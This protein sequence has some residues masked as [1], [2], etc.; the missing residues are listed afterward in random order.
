MTKD[1]KN[2]SNEVVS[3]HVRIESMGLKKKALKK[4]GQ[5]GLGL[6]QAALIIG[7][8]GATAEAVDAAE[9]AKY[10]EGSEGAKEA[11]NQALKVARSKPA[12][13]IAAGITCL[14]Y[15][16]AAGV[17]SSPS[18]CVTCGILLA[19]TLGQQCILFD[20]S[21]SNRC[22]CL[23]LS[24]IQTEIGTE[25]FYVLRDDMRNCSMAI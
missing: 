6:L 23:N 3:T 14:A 4:L 9:A 19:K 24:S 21:D 7:S 22:Y 18:I 20:Q 2:S 25:P 16:P 12:L 11:V 15:I 5:V 13:S 1:N 10:V 8:T 17:A